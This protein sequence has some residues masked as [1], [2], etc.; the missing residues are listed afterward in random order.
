MNDF[1]RIC[2]LLRLNIPDFYDNIYIPFDYFKAGKWDVLNVISE[3]KDAIYYNK[4]HIYPKNKK[5]F[6][7]VFKVYLETIMEIFNPKHNLF[8][9]FEKWTDTSGVNWRGIKQKTYLYSLLHNSDY[10][11]FSPIYLHDLYLE[12]IKK[13]GPELSLVKKRVETILDAQLEKV[14]K[15]LENFEEDFIKIVDNFV[16]VKDSKKVLESDL[17]NNTIVLILKYTEKLLKENIYCIHPIISG[18]ID[19]SLPLDDI[20]TF[21]PDE[22]DGMEL[23]IV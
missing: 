16:Y 19:F 12:A 11:H 4:T 21:D 5:Y 23:I 22:H 1:H 14:G 18:I 9:F 13:Y 2:R 6:D 7:K 20:Y 15:I 8:V 3:N 10:S 17:I